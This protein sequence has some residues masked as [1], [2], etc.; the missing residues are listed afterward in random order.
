MHK[1]TPPYI[2]THACAR[3]QTK[4]ERG[5]RRRRRKKWAEKRRKEKR[6]DVGRTHPAQNLPTTAAPQCMQNM[7]F[8]F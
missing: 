8:V 4:Q 2:H 1:V 5:H 6:K 3:A 7:P